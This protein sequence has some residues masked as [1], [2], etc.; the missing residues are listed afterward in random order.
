[1][2]L[3]LIST[4]LATSALIALTAPVLAQDKTGPN[5][6]PAAK[7]ARGVVSQMA[8]AQDLYA[9]GMSNKDALTVLAAARIA[10]SV[11]ATDVERTKETKAND[12][13]EVADEG[14][15]VD[16]PVDAAAMLASAKELAVGDQAIL[17][18]IADAETEGSRGRIGGASRTLSRLP[19]GNTD[20]WTIPYYG[21]SLAEVAIVGDGDADLD[22]LVTDEYGNTVCYDT[23]Y[24]DKIY[25]SWVPSWNSNF[26]VA[27]KN[28]G[29]KRNSYY[30]YTN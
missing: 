22:I 1:M 8:L 14:D 25:C 7:A 21:N 5:V 23:S 20:V 12:G 4:A 16:G 24:S 9:L 30:L 6:D 2:K 17:D 15:G 3:K 10:G 18:M 11:D 26:Y 19:R 28:Q 27:V 29:Y 13:A